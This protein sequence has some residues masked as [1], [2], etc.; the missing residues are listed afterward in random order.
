[1]SC[2]YQEACFALSIVCCVCVV[3]GLCIF[4]CVCVSHGDVYHTDGR[5]ADATHI[6]M[7]SALHH[8]ALR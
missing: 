7:R 5:V 4:V 8:I 3:C 2:V 1:M 6:N